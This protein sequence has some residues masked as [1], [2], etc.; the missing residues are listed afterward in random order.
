[1]LSLPVA[2]GLPGAGYQGRRL[3]ICILFFCSG[4][5]SGIAVLRQV[6][7]GPYIGSGAARLHVWVH[8]TSHL[9][10]QAPHKPHTWVAGHSGSQQRVC[11]NKAVP[12]AM[13]LF[14]R[15]DI[16]APCGQM[17]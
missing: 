15:L 13:L 5:I 7:K 10:D 17:A 2:G 9:S 8:L 12:S 16:A 6:I 11:Q 14:L 1:M 3:A 4:C